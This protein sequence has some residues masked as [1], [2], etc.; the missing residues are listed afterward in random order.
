MNDAHHPDTIKKVITQK[1]QFAWRYNTPVWQQFKDLALDV[2]IRW[3]LE[4]RGHED[5]GRVLPSNYLF[6]AGAQGGTTGFA[7]NS[8]RAAIGTGRFSP[9]T[10]GRE[11]LLSVDAAPERASAS[12]VGNRKSIVGRAVNAEHSNALLMLINHVFFRF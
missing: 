11:T 10:K 9:R 2:V 5:V 4:K 8:A 1:H 6:F 7:T 12:L 3:E